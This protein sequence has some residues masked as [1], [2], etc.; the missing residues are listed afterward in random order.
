MS[1]IDVYEP[2]NRGLPPLKKYAKQLF[3]RRAFISEFAKSELRR[4]NF[5]SPLGQIWL[6]L[7]PLLLSAV[8]FLLI[9]I[10]SGQTDSA[11]YAHLTAGLFVFYLITNSITA[12]AKSI[13]AGGRLILNSAFP[14]IM[15]PIAASVVALFKFIPTLIVLFAIH[16]ILGLPITF[17]LFWAIPLIFIF[18]IF[19]LACAILFSCINVYF[20][21]IQN[22]LPYLTRT[23]LYLSPVLYESSALTEKLSILKTINPLYPMLDSWSRVMVKGELPFA[24][25]V[26]QSLIWTLALLAISS[27][28][29]LSRERE[30]AVRI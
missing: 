8:Y 3:G 15:L 11:R 19:S 25:D 23:L 12:G 4:Q 10:I 5:G 29:F 28:L 14:R 16:I 22:L 6:V 20:R 7:N 30:F 2:F 24:A 9:I 26:F 27:Y 13:T 1:A 17:A 21:D 18:Y